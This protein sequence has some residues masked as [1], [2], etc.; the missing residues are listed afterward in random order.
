MACK[1]ER[2]SNG[3]NGDLQVSFRVP[4]KIYS[5]KNCQFVQGRRHVVRPT[6]R[7]T[8]IPFLS[9]TFLPFSKQLQPGP[10]DPAVQRLKE[11]TGEMS[12][13]RVNDSSDSDDESTHPS[14]SPSRPLDRARTSAQRVASTAAAALANMTVP[15]TERGYSRI[16]EGEDTPGEQLDLHGSEQTHKDEDAEDNDLEINVRFGEGQ[17]LS[18]RVPRTHTIAQMKEKVA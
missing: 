9:S 2:W 15:N 17:D 12:Y 3:K 18:L 5:S 1:S 16:G 8:P 7:Q 13:V 4:H 10:K 11:T 6:D 14:S